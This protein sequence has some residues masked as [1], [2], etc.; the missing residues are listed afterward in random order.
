MIGLLLAVT[1]KTQLREAPAGQGAAGLQN[2]LELSPA[3]LFAVLYVVLSVS[4]VLVRNAM[5][6]VGLLGLAAVVGITDIVPF[7]VPIVRHLREPTPL[8]VSAIVLAAMSNVVVRG[9]YCG[10]LVPGERRETSWRHAL[11]ALLHLPLDY[12]VQ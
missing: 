5:G 10:T 11:W 8:A 4:T 7:I 1:V 6:D 3:L 2:P 12:F 9:I